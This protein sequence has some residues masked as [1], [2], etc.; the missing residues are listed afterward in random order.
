MTRA[1]GGK[2][3]SWARREVKES[4][5]QDPQIKR[6]ACQ[7]NMQRLVT[8]TGLQKQEE[9]QAQPGLWV[10]SVAPRTITR[11]RRGG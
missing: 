10:S 9:S 8:G 5:S 6:T 1:R 4:P 7:R 2:E 11:K 3:Q